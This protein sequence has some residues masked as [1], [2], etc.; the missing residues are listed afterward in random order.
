MDNKLARSLLLFVN[1]NH[2]QES[3]RKYAED[4]IKTLHIQL[5]S[6]TEPTKIYRIQGQIAEI[7]R[8]LT[9][10]EEVIKESQ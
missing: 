4:R 1:D 10:R 3:V 5:E 2:N 7:K 6:I 8:L 9:L